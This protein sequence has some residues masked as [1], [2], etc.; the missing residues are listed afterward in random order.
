MSSWDGLT[1]APFCHVVSST[2]SNHH[3]YVCMCT[4]LRL[5]AGLSR[6][7]GIYL[8]NSW[9]IAPF[10]GHSQCF[11]SMLYTTVSGLRTRLL[12]LDTYNVMYNLMYLWVYIL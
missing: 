11:F 12:S 3:R 9:Y 10:P 5:S 6:N 1:K 8:L 7:C 4:R 2:G